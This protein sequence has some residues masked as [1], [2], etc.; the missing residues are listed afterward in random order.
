MTDCKAL[1]KD[2]MSLITLCMIKD[3]PYHKPPAIRCLRF[4][5]GTTDKGHIIKWKRYTPGA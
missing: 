2:L 1:P 3:H 5:G 4:P